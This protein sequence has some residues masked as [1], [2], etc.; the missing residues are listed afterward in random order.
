MVLETAHLQVPRSLKKRI[1]QK[2]YR[3]TFDQAFAQVI[4]AC[5]TAPRPGQTGTWITVGMREAYIELHRQGH[6]H[7]AEAWNG[8]GEL[9]GGVYGVAVGR[10]F[11]G[12]SM[13]AAAPDASKIAFVALVE[14]LTRW[15]F[16]VIDCQMYTDHLARF[17][18]VEVPREN[19]LSALATLARLPPL[20]GPW[21]ADL[22]WEDLADRS[23]R[24]DDP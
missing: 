20:P 17:G 21:A 2:P 8:E 24:S 10:A 23:S 1:R 6:A 11:S 16:P 15:G 4:E 22:P 5:A 12:E 18:A 14:H 7:S 19:W 13:F 3:I 9:V